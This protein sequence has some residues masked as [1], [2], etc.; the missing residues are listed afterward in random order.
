MKVL[1]YFDGC[2]KARSL[3]CIL[4]YRWKHLIIVL[5]S[6]NNIKNTRPCAST[7]HKKLR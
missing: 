6:Q 7:I 2:I 3:Y 5:V 4:R 1:V